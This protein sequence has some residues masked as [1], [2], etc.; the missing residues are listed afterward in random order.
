M[1][2]VETIYEIRCFLR[3]LSIFSL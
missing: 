2:N 1:R 3:S